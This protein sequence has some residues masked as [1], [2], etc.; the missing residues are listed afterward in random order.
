MKRLRALLPLTIAVLVIGG[1][2]TA[3]R[4]QASRQDYLAFVE[5]RDLWHKRCDVYRDTPLKGSP[6]AQLCDK[7]L[8]EL[9]AYA[10]A[11]GWN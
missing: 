6:A 4:I 10:K 2:W 3:S 11:K 8:T 5:R 9:V 1:L 7:E